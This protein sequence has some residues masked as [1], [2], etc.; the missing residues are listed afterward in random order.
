M[1][2]AAMKNA[3]EERK[4]LA[5]ALAFAAYCGTA[6]A[7]DD[8]FVE[9]TRGMPSCAQPKAPVTTPE[10]ARMEAH[11]RSERG[12]RCYLDG[13]CR[14]PN[15]YQ[16][17]A[18]IIPRV[19]KAILAAVKYGDTTVSAFG[20]RRWEFLLGCVH[21]KAQSRALEDLVK[22]IDDVERVVNRLGVSR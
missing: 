7:Y 18:E 15:S 13:R 9:V 20:Q 4:K 6:S 1:K 14:L 22:G 19:K 10:Q 3:K 5:I 11:L 17:D 8:P 12:T 16:Y 21:S 2:Y